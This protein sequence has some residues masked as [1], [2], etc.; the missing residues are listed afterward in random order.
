VQQCTLSDTYN[1]IHLLQ[2]EKLMNSSPVRELTTSSFRQP[3]LDPEEAAEFLGGLNS[4]TVTRW[5]LEG[6][7]PAFPVG[8]GKR[9]LW[10]FRERDLEAWMLSRQT[11]G[12]PAHIPPSRHTLNVA[13]DAP[14]K[15]MKL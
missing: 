6:Y 14:N 11:G 1:A 8:E 2:M 3:F 5:A 12:I 10:R 13:T 7:L 4:R 9:R 15:E